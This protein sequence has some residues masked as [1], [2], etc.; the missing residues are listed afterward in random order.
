MSDS[1]SSRPLD[2]GQVCLL[3][4]G[5]PGAGKSTV[6]RLLAA[7]L[8]LSSV[9]NGDMIG[10]LVVSGYVWPLGEPA[11]EAARQ[12]AL[13]NDNL[14][15]LARNFMTAGF[16]PVIDWVIPD[17]KQLDVFRRSIGP[18]LRLI[19]LDPGAQTC[20]E[21]NTSRDTIEQ[22]TY[23]GYAELRASMQAGFG[24][25]GWWLN[26]SGLTPEA[27]VQR[28]LADADANARLTWSRP[29]K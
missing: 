29:P 17:A 28:I 5:A 25:H 18:Q 11:D 15:S 2:R 21:R 26:T 13:C 20:R 3:V 24:V 23:N 6:S 22:F 4:T 16:T 10:G 14:C 1:S 9:L 12:A 7:A 19:V 27:T 8:T